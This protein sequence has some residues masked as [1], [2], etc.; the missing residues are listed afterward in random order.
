MTHLGDKVRCCTS[1]WC[2]Y[3]MKVSWKILC[4]S[5]CTVESFLV[6]EMDYWV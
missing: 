4:N 2:N 6:I 1:G 5:C 3:A